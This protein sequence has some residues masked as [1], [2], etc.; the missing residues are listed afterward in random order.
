[1]SSQLIIKSH[2]PWKF[3]FKWIAFSGVIGVVAWLSYGYG[4][5]R[6]GQVNATL[7][8]ELTRLQETIYDLG[9]DNAELRENYALLQRTGQVDKES[10]IAINDEL[11][12]LQT[13]MLELKQQVA[14][15]RGIVSP[16]EGASGLNITN[17]RIDDIGSDNSYRFK[18]VLT[19]VNKNDRLVSGKAR[20]VID[21]IMAGQQKQ[22]SLTEVSG[23]KLNDLKMKFKYFQNIEGDIV[24]PEGFVPSRVSVDVIPRGK[25][26]TR[27][28]KSYDWSDITS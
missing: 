22:L 7:E 11:K 15:Y 14:F 6:S 5:L 28:K 23:G 12:N 27:I 2:S 4:Q 18:L 9:R 20:I 8:Q 10:Y 16:T 24:L 17:L 1:M 13:E 25:G 3:W 21:G 26:L 19:Q